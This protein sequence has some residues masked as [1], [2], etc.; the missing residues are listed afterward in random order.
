MGRIVFVEKNPK[1][2]IAF[3][4]DTMDFYVVE[5]VVKDIYKSILK[6]G[7]ER[8]K[9][10][11]DISQKDLDSIC[12]LLC[13][14]DQ[15][16]MK[17]YIHVEDD[18]I[19]LDKLVLNVTNVCNLNCAYCYACGGSY[20]SDE[21][22]MDIHVAKK[23]IDVFFSYFDQ[24]NIL[25]FFG[26]E[27]LINVKLIEDVCAYLIEKKERGEI[28]KIPTLG[29]VTNGTLLTKNAIDIIK[30]YG[31]GVTVSLDGDKYIHDINRYDN[32][33]N[34][35][36]EL[37]MSNVLEL[38]KQTKQPST[39]EVTYN[40]QHVENDISIKSI[41]NHF[42][43]L[44]PETSFHIV[45]V[46]TEVESLRLE[47]REAFVDSVDD[48]FDS[49]HSENAFTYSLVQRLID[50]IKNKK[51]NTHICSAG[52]GTLS[53]DING[54]VYP[55]FM[56]T[57]EKK[58]NMGTIYE[59]DLFTSKKMKEIREIFFQHG[60]EKDQKCNDCMLQQFCCGCHGMNYYKN[61]DINNYEEDFCQM[62][63]RMAEKVL[64]DLADYVDSLEQGA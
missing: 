37:I 15:Q 26:G 42:Q 22:I 7:L 61:G 3:N 23:T 62:N 1:E 50:A 59:N 28:K 38:Y 16:C 2:L 18:M 40:Q 64:I 25:Q 8:T 45:P 30:K 13:N 33:G 44:L 60:K 36:Y 17:E 12:E 24:I 29:I 31:I 52:L 27:P 57:D 14:E 11:Y 43:L 10:K 54:N 48:I 63:I 4:K 53:V 34:G 47:N 56:F 58:F 20:Q 46:S 21:G 35:T 5:P 6:Q 32:N 39:I 9:E 51:R 41:V 19:I 55:C 49:L